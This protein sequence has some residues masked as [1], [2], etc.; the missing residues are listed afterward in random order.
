MGFIMRMGIPTVNK[1]F[2]QM[3]GSASFGLLFNKLWV[4]L[5]VLIGQF[6]FVGFASEKPIWFSS[7]HGQ[8]SA[9]KVARGRNSRSWIQLQFTDTLSGPGYQMTAGR[10]TQTAWFLLDSAGKVSKAFHYPSAGD[11]Q[12]GDVALGSD[13]SMVSVG[14]FLAETPWHLPKGSLLGHGALDAWLMRFQPNGELEWGM[15][16]GGFNNDVALATW[17]SENGHLWLAGMGNTLAFDNQQI[18]AGQTGA[19]VASFS[20]KARVRWARGFPASVFAAFHDVWVDSIGRTV[21]VGQFMG[22]WVV[23]S[24]TLRGGAFAQPCMVVLNDEGKIIKSQRILCT[25]DA[26]LEQVNGAGDA[27]YALA[28][29]YQGTLI[30]GSDTLVGEEGVFRPFVWWLNA[31]FSG[32]GLMSLP[33]GA[34]QGAP[35]LYRANRGGV[36]LGYVAASASKDEAA[37]TIRIQHYY[38]PQKAGAAAEFAIPYATRVAGIQTTE[39]GTLLV[40]G[41]ASDGS[42][43]GR[44]RCWIEEI[45]MPRP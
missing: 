23:E 4:S 3:N 45:P 41:E 36:W 21:A 16:A 17:V 5:F 35:A 15:A 2:S 19:L 10:F 8:V 31:R 30:S 9:I 39:A 43:E 34:M 32:Y 29:Q 12:S 38:S 26:V 20:S 11:Q 7:R 28:G 18:L 24:D 1:R 13:G 25:G 6:S 37:S 44:T 42:I 40:W 22:D 27:G 33:S 14:A